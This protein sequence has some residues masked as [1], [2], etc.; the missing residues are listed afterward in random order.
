M[1]TQNIHNKDVLKKKK[2]EEKEK[3]QEKD[4]DIYY[5]GKLLIPELAAIFR[6][7]DSSFLNAL[8]WQPCIY[9]VIQTLT[10][11]FQ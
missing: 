11:S 3:K 6:Q 7:P 10:C 4:F 1:R 5:F 2:K 9:L 8:V